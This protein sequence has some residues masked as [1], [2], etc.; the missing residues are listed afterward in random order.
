MFNES[1]DV[2]AYNE[3]TT[4]TGRTATTGNTDAAVQDYSLGLGFTT[5]ISGEEVSVL[6]QNMD[7]GVYPV[8]GHTPEQVVL[9]ALAIGGGVGTA[10]G[11][12]AAIVE[13]DKRK[14]EE[15]RADE[16]Q[17]LL[18]NMPEGEGGN[19]YT[20]SHDT[21]PDEHTE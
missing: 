11:I 17:D 19:V 16:L 10:L 14:A 2:G 5:T 18:D 8:E 1:L 13:T 7:I 3:H 9:T 15:A 21:A 12:T 6:T 4:P 20:P